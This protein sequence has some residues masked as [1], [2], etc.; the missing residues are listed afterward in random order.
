[1]LQ[2]W[3][4]ESVDAR[5]AESRA[6]VQSREQRVHAEPFEQAEALRREPLGIDRQTV[7]QLLP[8]ELVIRADPPYDDIIEQELARG[9]RNP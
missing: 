7:R 5:E 3:C 1:M 9:G 8:A 4:V 6:R 2:S